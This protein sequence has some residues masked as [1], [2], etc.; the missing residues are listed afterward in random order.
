MG[1]MT[2]TPNSGNNPNQ[3]DMAPF[4]SRVISGDIGSFRVD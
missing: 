3:A 1:H 2:V 4:S